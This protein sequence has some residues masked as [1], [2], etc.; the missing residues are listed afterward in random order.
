[1]KK[2]KKKKRKKGGD[3]PGGQAEAQASHP[4]PSTPVPPPRPSARPRSRPNRALTPSSP[5]H[6]WP[7]AGPR[8]SLSLTL[9][10][11][12]SAGAFSS[13]LRRVRAGHVSTRINPG[14]SQFPCPFRKPSTIKRFPSTLQFPFATKSR[15]RARAVPVLEF[16]ISPKTS[17][18]ASPLC[19]SSPRVNRPGELAGCFSIFPCTRLEFWCTGAREPTTPASLGA[20]PMAHHRAGAVS[21]R[22]G[23]L[24]PPAGSEP[25][26]RRL[27]DR[28]R[29]Y[30]F[31]VNLHRVPRIF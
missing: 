29:R 26:D 3:N 24:R 10:P 4:Q 12:T 14:K 20:S 6:L 1:L 11:R 9:G 25:F 22:A 13:S 17:T 16:W 7:T 2:K 27:T 18:A 19:S 31:A 8:P 15:N 21:L 23:H 30:L 28:I 5:F